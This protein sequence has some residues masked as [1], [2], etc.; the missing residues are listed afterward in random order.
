MWEIYNHWWHLNWNRWSTIGS[1]PWLLV[2]NGCLSFSVDVIFIHMV[3]HTT[4]L[5]RSLSLGFKNLY[6]ISVSVIVFDTPVTVLQYVGYGITLIAIIS[7]YN[8][9]RLIEAMITLQLPITATT[10][11]SYWS[12]FTSFTRIAYNAITVYS[13]SG[14]V[15]YDE[16]GGISSYSKT[17]S[18]SKE[19]KIESKQSQV[20][21]I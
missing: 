11:S 1:L 13:T 12:S 14:C 5:T 7:Q 8:N 2:L 4:T 20:F 15:T 6:L 16:G 18:N 21:L 9:L 19:E 3:K 17:L 10:A